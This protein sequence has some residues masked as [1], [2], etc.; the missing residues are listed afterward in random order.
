MSYFK[1][2]PILNKWAQDNTLHIYTSHQSYEVRSIDIVSP[3]GKRF[4]LWID[5]P[6]ENENILIHIWDLKMKQ[7]DYQC[8]LNNLFNKLN[9]AYKD[10]TNWF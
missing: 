1:I 9:E 4:Q 8:D 5:E 6:D 3:S 7:K 2:D 10:L